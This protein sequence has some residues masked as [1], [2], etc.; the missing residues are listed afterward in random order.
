[1]R[2]RDAQNNPVI[3]YAGAAQLSDSTGSISPTSTGAFTSG[4]WTGPVTITQAAAGATITVQDGLVSG[5]SNS[6]VVSTLQE[7]PCILWDGSAT[8]DNPYVTDG[9]PIELGVKFRSAVS[10]Y[11]LGVKF[12]KGAQNVGAHVGHLWSADGTQLAE[13][14]F[15]GETTSGW[16]QVSF[17][18]PVAIDANTT[19]IASYYSPEGG[20]AF[21]DYGFNTQISN[22]PLSA[23]ADGEDGPN[24]VFKYYE[25]GFPTETYTGHAPNYWVDVVFTQSTAADTTPPVSVIS[26]SPANNA[27]GVSTSPNIDAIFSEAMNSATITMGTFEL[28]DAG[29]TLVPATVSYASSTRKATLTVSS[30]LA[31]STIY[32]VTLKGGVGGTTD[33]A[34]NPLAQ[35]YVWSFITAAT[36]PPPPDEGP[37]GPILVIS[38]TTNPFGRYYAEI[39]R[40]EGLNAFFV[41]DITSVTAQVLSGYDVV[42]LGGMALTSAQ[43]TMI[44]SWVQT[45]GNLIAMRPDKQMAGLLG[46]ADA[47]GTRSNQYLRVD[48][49]QGAGAGVTG[50]TIQ[51]HGSADLYLANAGT[52]VLA[53]LY[54]DAATHHQP[55]GRVG[56]R[57]DRWRPGRGLYL[58]P[59]AFGGVHPQGNPAW[60]GDERDG[61]RYGRW[62]C[63]M[64][65]RTVTCS[66]TG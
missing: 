15:V 8:P 23:L 19:Y 33:L 36:P 63:S 31:Y 27:S 47:S 20:F 24:G 16:Q 59:G 37:G 66:R 49:T 35:D 5:Q 10:G 50:E 29:N 45:G 7:C 21:S 65:T 54:S 9:I 62:M 25:T 38:S 12:Y 39:L 32:R 18:T 1:M 61:I 56:F 40:N 34:G 13:A 11:I 55:G 53:T 22:P 58:R 46:L 44:S 51:F 6:F 64:A 52:Q 30:A 28:R 3:T 60:A 57:R 48:T 41:T 2:A 4:V 42:I 17:G 26:V 14:A 43:V